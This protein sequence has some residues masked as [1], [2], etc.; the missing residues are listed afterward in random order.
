MS[1]G[2]VLTESLAARS[3]D[4]LIASGDIAHDPTQATYRL[5]YDLVRSHYGGHF[6]VT[7]GNH[8]IGCAMEGVFDLGPIDVTNWTIV[9]L[10]T[11][12]EDQVSGVVSE[13][14][15]MQLQRSLER[16]NEHVIVVGHHP[17]QNVDVAWLDEHRVN[18]AAEVLSILEMTSQVKAYVCGHVHLDS[19]KYHGHVKLWTTPSTCWQFASDVDIF[20]LS[21]KAPGWR[22]LELHAD[23]S[24][25]SQVQRLSPSFTV[26]IA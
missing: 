11:H 14:N 8:D 7:P 17:L 23:G 25:D 19:I 26:G 1:L 21:P 4:V 20:E 18:N 5:F 16:A 10:D 24:I 12:R 9:P 22:W 15:L 3:P 2:A 13:E 6:L